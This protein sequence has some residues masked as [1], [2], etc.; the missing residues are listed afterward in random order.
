[1]GSVVMRSSLPAGLLLHVL[2]RQ[3]LW[4]ARI[5]R[6]D[7]AGSF[8]VLT[9]AVLAHATEER[10][11]FRRQRRNLVG[12]QRTDQTRCNEHHELGLF[13]TLCLRL[14]QWPDDR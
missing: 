14:E 12:I 2:V 4:L 9:C 3:L 1:M 8:E 11:E 5:R 7:R 6:V 13:G 10:L